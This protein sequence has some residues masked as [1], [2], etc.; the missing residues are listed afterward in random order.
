M[1]RTQLFYHFLGLY[2]GF[3]WKKTRDFVAGFD[4]LDKNQIEEYQLQRLKEVVNHAYANV[5]FYHTFYD[6]HGFH[7]SQINTLKDVELIPIINKET[8]KENRD[9]FIADNWK[10][11]KP[12]TRTTGGT[13]GQA[14]KFYTDRK[15]WAITWAVK[16]H[17]FKQAGFEMGKHKLGVLAGGS[18]LPQ[19]GATFKKRVWRWLMNYYSMPIS[20]MT[21]E[22][23]E[24]YYQNLKQQKIKYL[25]GYPTAIYTLAKYMDQHGKT[26]QLKAVFTT[27]E[28]LYDHHRELFRK[29]FLCET[30]NEYGCGD[31]N[32]HALECPQHNGLHLSPELSV[33]N[34]VDENG[35]EVNNGEEG[36]LVFTSLQDFSMPFIRF[37]PGDMAVKT[38][39]IC[40]CG[41]NHTLIQKIIGRSSDLIEFSNG[42]K[43][44]G[45]S[46]PF[47]AWTEKVKRFQIVQTEHDAIELNIVPLP[48]LTENDL[49]NAKKVLEY[50]CGEGVKVNI[51]LVDA[52]EVPKSGK[53]RYVISKIDFN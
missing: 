13:T 40:A 38:D 53:F 3:S 31:G 29:V 10:D 36:E 45:L 5:P 4:K 7:P 26:L 16:M 46:I 27:A 21:D 12:T 34:I 43:I 24:D 23:M 6:T 22:I 39:R 19:K 37:K 20:H 9:T 1:N 18:L 25:R 51:N 17:F 44:N 48:M 28:M 33:T 50:H 30:Y 42:R 11:F 2:Y 32:G 15:S 8:I 52:I 35:N 47:E 14:F 49:D 41:I